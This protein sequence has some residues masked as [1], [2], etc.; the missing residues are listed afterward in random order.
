MGEIARVISGSARKSSEKHSTSSILEDRPVK[1][2]EAPTYEA[3][4]LRMRRSFP[5]SVVSNRD[6]EELPVDHVSD[7]LNIG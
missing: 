7:R 2:L 6:P 3:I 5:R 4:A 1:S